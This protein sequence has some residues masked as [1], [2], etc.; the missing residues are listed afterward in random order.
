MPEKI[1]PCRSVSGRSPFKTQEG[2]VSDHSIQWKQTSQGNA[3]DS[4]RAMLH[5]AEITKHFP[6]LSFVP[7]D[8]PGAFEEAHL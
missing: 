4:A 3:R 8:F 7:G 5:L 1:T 6:L 2:V